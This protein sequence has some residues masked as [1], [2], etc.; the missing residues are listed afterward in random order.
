MKEAAVQHLSEKYFSKVQRRRQGGA[1]SGNAVK[2]NERFIDQRSTLACRDDDCVFSMQDFQSLNS[3]KRPLFLSQSQFPRSSKGAGLQHWKPFF[4]HS[5]WSS[6]WEWD[7]KGLSN[8]LVESNHSE[9]RT[10]ATNSKRNHM[11]III[12]SLCSVSYF[13][14]MIWSW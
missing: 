7:E 12:N 1:G 13:D 11:N 9:Y 3:V 10:L 8:S 14:H 6:S 5:E 4:L 2:L